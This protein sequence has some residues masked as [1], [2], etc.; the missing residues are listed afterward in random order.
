LALATGI[1]G[2]SDYDKTTEQRAKEFIA[3]QSNECSTD[4]KRD[5]LSESKTF[6]LKRENQIIYTI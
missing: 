1:G 3:K 4:V 5:I 2:D 6:L